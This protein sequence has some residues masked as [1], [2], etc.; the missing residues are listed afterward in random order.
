MSIEQQL[1]VH[2]RKQDDYWRFGMLNV[3]TEQLNNH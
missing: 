1:S 3:P 2:E